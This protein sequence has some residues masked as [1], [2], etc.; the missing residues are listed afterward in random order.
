MNKVEFINS[1]KNINGI[2]S[3]CR[4]GSYGAKEWIRDRSDIDL[5]VVVGPN[6][7]FM[8]TI[9]IEDEVNTL[10]IDFY[11]YDKIH[12]T[13]VHYSDF[14]NKFAR[15]AVD[16]D[17]Q[18]IVNDDLWFDFMHY[19]LKYARNNRDFEKTLKIDEQYSYFGG[20]IDESIL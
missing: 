13:F 5:A 8:D 16:S 15:I 10:C 19:V 4:F 11:K 1:L 17:E 14:Y 7:N 2:V 12:L 18:Y 20:I 3:V 6:V 9:N